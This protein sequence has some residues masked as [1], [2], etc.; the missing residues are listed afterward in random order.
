MIHQEGP[1]SIF[2]GLGA[3]LIAL[4]P[5]WI[6]YFV[7]YSQYR[8]VMEPLFFGKPSIPSEK[9][10]KTTSIPAKSSLGRTIFDISNAVFGGLVTCVLTN[11]LWLV[12]SRLQ[13][14]GL[15]QSGITGVKSSI[16]LTYRGTFHALQTIYRTE[17]FLA[18]YQGV[19]PQLFGLLHVGIHFPLYEHFKR[20]FM[21]QNI[22]NAYEKQHLAR[23]AQF[24]SG[25]LNVDTNS[26]TVD[27]SLTTWQIVMASTFSKLVACLA[28]YPHEVL[29]SR[30]QT[31]NFLHAT[32]T[33]P[34]PLYLSMGHAVRTIHRDEGFRGFYRGLSITL[35]R[36]VPSCIVTFL[37][38]EKIIAFLDKYD[39]SHRK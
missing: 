20:N 7:A 33:N 28:A 26:L 3:N 31:Q 1:F 9:E 22:R 29:R 15:T 39:S 14:Q 5:N 35:L 17:G 8:K 30:F 10:R 11:P 16:P 36:S 2:R 32:S 37:T 19:I 12:K 34:S 21:E 4:I 27:T 25:S 6:T 24:A 23:V 18:L 38:Y 13:V